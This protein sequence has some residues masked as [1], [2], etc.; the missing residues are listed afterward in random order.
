MYYF[1]YGSN[2]DNGELKRKGI[3]DVEVFG[4]AILDGYELK[5]NKLSKKDGSGKANIIRKDGSTVEGVIY[6]FTKEQMGTMDTKEGSGYKQVKVFPI[7]DGKNIE[8]VAYVAT[9][10]ALRENLLPTKDYLEKILR[11][12]KEFQLSDSYTKQLEN[13]DFLV[14]NTR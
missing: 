11:G 7:S 6:I 8:A 1:A 2:M 4:S 13:Q 12:A 10:T 5:F 3:E 9:G 14:T